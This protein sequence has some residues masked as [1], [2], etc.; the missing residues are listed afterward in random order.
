V[1]IVSAFTSEILRYAVL[2]ELAHEAARRPLRQPNR[3][4][5]AGD[6]EHSHICRCYRQM[7]A[8]DLAAPPAAEAAL[9][10]NSA[11][12]SRRFADATSRTCRNAS[13][14]K[15]MPA[16]K[17]LFVDDEAPI[18]DGYRRL[19]R[20]EFLVSTA[21]SGEEGLAAIQANGP[22]PVVI[23]DMRM[24]GMNGAEFLAQV[25][26]RAP[27][28]VRMLL[29]GH[30]DLDTAIDAVNRGNIFRFLTKPCEKPT[31]MEAIRSGLEVYRAASADKE[32]VKKAKL[33]AESKSGWET[34]DIQPAETPETPAGLP[35]PSEA[36]AHLATRLGNDSQC[37]VV[38]I[39]V[40]LLRTVEERYGEEAALRYLKDAVRFVLQSLHPGDRLFYWSHGVLMAVIER[41][42][43]APAVRME[44]SR[45][46]LDCPQHVLELNGSKTMISLSTSFDL[47]PAVLF[48]TFEKLQSAFDAKLIGKI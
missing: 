32:M 5:A 44:V 16:D 45:V 23:S 4:S 19:L 39:K 35:G 48:P 42:L 20:Q 36:E 11:D 8:D 27:D 33:I 34:A 47:F 18:L 22:Y 38:L 31:L 28:S 24:P 7:G 40:G 29:T 14:R 25:R 6:D 30:A 13:A 10:D 43:T 21:L 9:Q 17:I 46:L 26:R 15:E 3:V 37:F 1:F 41:H 2:G 12:F